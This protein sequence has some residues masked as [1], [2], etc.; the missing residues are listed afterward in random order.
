[1]LRSGVQCA[2]GCL[3]SGCSGSTARFGKRLWHLVLNPIR[4]TPCLR[5]I[6]ALDGHLARAS[7]STGQW[8]VQRVSSG[9]AEH[10][11]MTLASGL[12]VCG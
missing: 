1:M 7:T 5:C 4:N 9:D 8:A 2:I 12:L 6:L 3:C 11:T 10:H